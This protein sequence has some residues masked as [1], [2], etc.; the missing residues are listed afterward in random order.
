MSK[1][2]QVYGL[3]RLALVVNWEPLSPNRVQGRHWGTVHKR[4][5]LA[6]K[7]FGDALLAN[8]HA[9]EVLKLA[10]RSLSSGSTLS[11]AEGNCSTSTTTSPAP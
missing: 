8:Q 11:L 2:L 3:T 6:R 5:K 1:P 9:L 7:A 10:R 4:R